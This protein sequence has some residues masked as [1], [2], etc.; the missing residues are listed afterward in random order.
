MKEEIISVYPHEN[1][2]NIQAAIYR[3]NNRQHNAMTTRGEK[4]ADFVDALTLLEIYEHPEI[5]A[6]NRDMEA[7]S[8][9][10]NRA[11]G[12]IS[13]VIDKDPVL[14]HNS[15]G[16]ACHMGQ[17][18]MAQF[19][20]VVGKR[21]LC[22]EVD[23]TI[24]PHVVNAG[25]F[26]GIHRPSFFAMISRDAAKALQATDDP[27]KQT[28]YY[29]REL[30]LFTYIIK[31]IEMGDCGSTETIPWLVKKGELD[32]ILPGK[33]YVDPVKGLMAIKAGDDHLV[34]KEIQ[35]RNVAS[36]WHPKDGT[37][38][39]TCM[40]QIGRSVQKGTNLGH[41][42]TVTQNE[43]V[44]QDVISTKH[45]LRSAETEGFEIDDF[46]KDWMVN[47][48]DIS[49]LMLSEK[50]WNHH[51]EV[52]IDMAYLPRLSDIHAL[53]TFRPQDLMRI[54]GVEDILLIAHQDDE[55]KTVTEELV[56]TS[57]SSY[58]PY[59]TEAF[60]KHMKDY[61][62]QNLG[63][64]IRVDLLHW[65]PSESILKFPERHS[66]TLE[67]ML[68]LKSN[69]FMSSKESKE[70]LRYDLTDP[71]ILSMALKD[72]TAMT[73]RKFSVNLAIVEI[74]L[75]AMMS[76]DPKNNDYRLPKKGTGRRFATKSELMSGRS[77]SMKCAYEKQ[78]QSILSPLSY[79]PIKES[80]PFD[81]LLLDVTKYKSAQ[82]ILKEKKRR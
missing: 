17:T 65:D 30:Q 18:K 77:L 41:A 36:C 40:G 60:I 76:R 3:G 20:Q 32:N 80:L 15:I 5:E 66:S 8:A 37:I 63:K 59:L 21:G 48:S 27:V 43:K 70:R 6:A 57:H 35:L 9:G 71:D 34:G 72:I 29:N 54:S 2:E 1:L 13:R 14:R 31:E 4:Y 44:S 55:N 73:N 79:D 10:I 12:V 81:H 38:C 28:E 45:L 26:E 39:S 51:V 64:K 47:A 11:Y 74:V 58:R 19:H 53:S 46:Y 42:A 56:S 16:A 24:F 49:E 68:E 52:E 62:F 22:S 67:M 50:I 82:D 7:T 69:I 61:G 78:Y 23:Q 75:F 25:F 33:F